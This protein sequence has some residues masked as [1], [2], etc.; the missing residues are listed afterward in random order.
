MM[1]TPRRTLTQSNFVP[2]LTITPALHCSCEGR[3][4]LQMGRPAFDERSRDRM[5]GILEERLDEVVSICLGDT[6]ERKDSASVRTISSMPGAETRSTKASRHQR[7]LLH[8]EDSPIDAGAALPRRKLLYQER[9][10]SSCGGISRAM[11]TGSSDG[12]CHASVEFV[13]RHVGKPIGDAVIH[14][15]PR[16]ALGVHLQNAPVLRCAE[17]RFV[18]KCDSPLA[19]R[20]RD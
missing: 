16:V 6:I 17:S 18:V 5:L 14:F 19:A 13:E 4:T 7:V 10:G 1:L 20:F 11:R 2:P 15:E 3:L 8:R 9:C 12:S